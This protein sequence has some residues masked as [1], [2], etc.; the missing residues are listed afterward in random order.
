LAEEKKEKAQQ[1]G[2]LTSA[3]AS[4]EGKMSELL[5]KQGAFIVADRMSKPLAKQEGL[6]VK[7]VKDYIFT[8]TNGTKGTYTGDMV[9]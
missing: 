5:A 4:V 9:G 2:Q 6:T 3:L 8:S 7:F 1:I